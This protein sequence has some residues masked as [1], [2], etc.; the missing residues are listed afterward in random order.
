VAI[1]ANL[2][3]T[4]NG[5]TEAP[6]TWQFPYFSPELGGVMLEQLGRSSGLVLG[7][8]TF[9]EFAAH[10]PSVSP[11]D[12]PMAA[13]I[14]GLPKYVAS[15]TLA[16][17][18]WHP[19]E[20][21]GD[22]VAGRLAELGEASEGDLSI[23]GSPTLVASLLD[24]GVVDRLSLLVFPIVV[25]RGRRLFDGATRRTELELVHADTLPND[26]LHLEYAVAGR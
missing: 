8:R 14:N 26:V 13:S 17:V 21:L 1:T 2:M 24:E 12:N 23:I 18:D 6:E 16:H 15:S 4:A 25:E 3:L 9:E 5:V 22:N 19:T 7:R 20:V 11:A 10:W